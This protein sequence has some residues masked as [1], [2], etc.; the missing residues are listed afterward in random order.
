[1]T[2]IICGIWHGNTLNFLYW[3]LWHGVGLILFKLWNIYI[4]KRHIEKIK[5][6]AL[7]VAYILSLLR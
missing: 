1:L 7:H 2:F 6:K 3:G 4:Y 5:A